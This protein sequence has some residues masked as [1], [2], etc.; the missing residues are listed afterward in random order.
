M[1]IVVRVVPPGK[2][3]QVFVLCSVYMVRDMEREDIDNYIEDTM[4]S[5]MQ[6]L[7]LVEPCTVACEEAHECKDYWQVKFGTILKPVQIRRNSKQPF[8]NYTHF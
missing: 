4:R 6:G 7:T 8:T 5:K 3:E 1:S 2:Q